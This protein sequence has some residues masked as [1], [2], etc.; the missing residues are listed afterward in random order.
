MI[1]AVDIGN[2]NVTFG[3]YDK[4]ELCATFSLETNVRS[5]A[6]TY[7]IQI[8]EMLKFFSI[9][10]VERIVVASVVPKLHR[11]FAEMS[12]MFFKKPH[13]FIL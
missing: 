12:D 2:T 13:H 6:A 9:D 4:L 7:F 11:V 10:S 1:L 5:T 8:S 3:I